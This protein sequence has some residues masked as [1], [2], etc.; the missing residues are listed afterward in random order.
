VNCRPIQALIFA[1]RA[2]DSVHRCL[3]FDDLAWTF[4]ALP[5]GSARRDM[6]L[7]DGLQN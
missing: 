3:R 1:A 6:T 5:A 7:R 4:R 2:E